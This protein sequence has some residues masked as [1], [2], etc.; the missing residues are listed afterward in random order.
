MK[1][2]SVFYIPS[3]GVETLVRQRSL[4]LKNRG[5]TNHFLYYQQGAGVQ[6]SQNQVFITNHDPSIQ[7]LIQREQ[8]DV[9]IVNSDYLFLPRI[10]NL[11][12]RGRLIYEVQ[13][14]GSIQQAEA[15]LNAAKQHVDPYADAILFPRTPHL[16]QLV[17]HYYPAKHKFCFNN[18]LDTNQFTYVN[19]L[20]AE[21]N[22]IIGWVGRLEENKNWRAFLDI[23]A[24]LVRYNNSLRIWV[25]S[26]DNLNSPSEKTDFQQKVQNLNLANHITH[27]SNVPHR[28]MPTFYSRIGNSGGFLLSTSKVEGFGYAIIEAMSCLCP[29]ICSDSD[30]IKSF[31]FHNETGKLFQQDHIQQAIQEA[32][33]LLSDPAL[34]HSIR[35]NGQKY[36]QTHFSPET[37]TANFIGMLQTLGIQA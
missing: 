36:I 20:P 37:Y 9:I 7:R 17:N 22:S 24:G 1:I 34:K 28:Q 3:G 2:L 4:A 23:C 21:S 6:N 25:F 26:D 29:V 27:Y 31:V 13:G 33:A 19:N 32:I 10:R 30:G 12:F 8:Y 15:T 16:I 18:C 5:I 35:I 14:L 11:G